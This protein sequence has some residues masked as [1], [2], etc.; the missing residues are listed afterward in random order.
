VNAVEVTT[1][2][3]KGKITAREGELSSSS[4]FKSKGILYHLS[5]S[6]SI[7]SLG[8]LIELRGFDNL[9]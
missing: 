6:S 5:S 1:V 3:C 4:S 9:D 2:G 7:A 8:V